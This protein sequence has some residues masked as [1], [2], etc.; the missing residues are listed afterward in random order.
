MP[1][2]RRAF[3]RSW[4]CR[5][6][7]TSGS[8][9]CSRS[10]RRTPAAF[11]DRDAKALRLLGGLVGRLARARRG[12]RVPAGPARGAHPGAAGERAAVQAAG[13]RGPGGDLDRGR[14]RGHHLRQSAD[15]GAAGLP[16]R[17]HAGPPGVRLL[18]RHRPRQR[19]AHPQ[20]AAGRRGEPGLP[21]P[22]AG[23]HRGVGPRV[24]EPGLGARRRRG[25]HGRHGHRHHRAEAH[26]GAAPALG[27]AAGDAAR[28]GS[29]DPRGPLAGRDR[30][31]GAGPRPADGPVPPLHRSSC[32][33]S[34]AARRT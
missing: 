34:R 24:G 2:T 9:G 25:G 19:P 28:H 7:T 16:E 33:T 11:S 13:R 20:P 21:L 5:C 4:P 32:S 18:R 31:R 6:A 15:G 12:V 1:I 22:E 3:A 10:C 29:G 26:R 8:S 17:G 14:P 30:T 23:R 27:R